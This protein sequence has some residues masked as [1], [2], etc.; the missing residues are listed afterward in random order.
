MIPARQM[1][2]RPATRLP[3]SGFHPP[4]RLAL[5]AL[6]V[7]S[8]LLLPMHVLPLLTGMLAWM[9]WRAGWR[10]R[11]MA[12]RWRIWWPL[13]AIVL[14]AHTVSAI[15]AAPLG[16][17]TW[18]GAGRGLLALARLS[19]MFASAGLTL[20]LLPMPM[21]SA[22][23]AWW[24]RPLRLIG[25]AGHHLNLALTVA[26]TTAPRTLAEAER[27]RNCLRLRM[28]RPERQGPWSRWLRVLRESWLIVPPLM[29]GLA[30]RADCLPLAL[31]GRVPADST[32]ESRLPWRQ[33]VL[34]AA[35]AVLLVLAVL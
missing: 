4:V 21:L 32:V 13:P 20:R 24:L 11:A 2:W 1:Y 35:W 25:P 10:P 26:A 5:G 23:L 8:A 31:V 14:V 28:G 12:A 3:L 6:A 33:A 7:L 27:L 18:T 34:V 15:D 9:L 22:A 19:L 30:R 29:E 17:P 16:S